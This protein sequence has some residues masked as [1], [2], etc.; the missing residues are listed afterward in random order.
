V[1]RSSSHGDA[2][3]GDWRS[4]D[5]PARPVLFVN[6]HSGDGRAQRA[7]LAERASSLGIRCVVL[8]PGS[9][10]AALA[11]DELTGGA[12][13]L[14]AAGGDGSLAIV[15]A[16]AR[17]HGVPFI[18]VPAGTRNHFARDV[19]VARHDLNG[20]L[21]AFTEGLERRI[22][23]GE[24]NGRVFLNNVSFGIYGDAV[25]RPGYRSAK[26]RTLLETAQEVLGPSTA[27]RRRFGSSTTAA[28]NTRSRP[29]S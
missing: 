5:P 10:L 21:A 23:I 16:A 18:C 13:A 11:H 22:D 27:R 17:A 9:D 4:V 14:G 25:Q 2:P 29:C 28:A 6:P 20:S 7:G 19:G 8:E 1:S 24:V 12:D 26:V 15:A 3:G